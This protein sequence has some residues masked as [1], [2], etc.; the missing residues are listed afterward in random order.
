[1]ARNASAA[2]ALA[3]LLSSSSLRAQSAPPAAPATSEMMVGGITK[4]SVHSKMALPQFG[5]ILELPVKEGQVVKQGDVL[6]KQDDRQEVAALEALRLEA[7]STVRIVAAEADLNIKQ[8]N[9]KR[10]E[11]LARGGNATA[12]ELEKA[13]VEAIYADAQVKIARLENEK[14]KREFE[15][16]RIKV[17][18]MTLRSPIDGIVEVID[19]SVG[20]VTDPQKPVLTI[21]KNDPLWVEF[22]L[23]TPQS[24]RLK[25]GQE[26]HIRYAGAQQQWQPAK[27][28]YK[29]PV[30]EYQSDTQKIRLEMRNAQLND[31]GLQVMVR[32]PADIGPAVVPSAAAAPARLEGPA[33]AAAAAAP[34]AR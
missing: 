8:L 22:F 23:P 24:S 7:D 13:Q 34:A 21:V 17:E 12:T 27:V 10:V 16:Q 11:D 2:V 9:L 32:L 20:E 1:M 19:V 15:R 18:Q 6:L 29:A 25:V 14:N 31:T 30:A 3:A 33:G 26:L 28:T 4:P 5:Q